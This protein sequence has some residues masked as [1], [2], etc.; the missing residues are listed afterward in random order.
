M[1]DNHFSNTSEPKATI[2]TPNENSTETIIDRD[3]A[4][5]INPLISSIMP[6][7]TLQNVADCIHSL[8][9]A[10]STDEAGPLIQSAW[11]FAD[12]MASAIRYEMQAMG[13]GQLL[14]G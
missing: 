8:G 11:L 10:I 12:V 5:I 1:T 2:E 7:G 4:A 6:A 13:N 3:T 9:T 14:D